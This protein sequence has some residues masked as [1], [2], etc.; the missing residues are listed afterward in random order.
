[1]TPVVRAK[2]DLL[3][4]AIREDIAMLAQ[5]CEIASKYIDL[6]RPDDGG[7]LYSLRS[8]VGHARIIAACARQLRDLRNPP[9]VITDTMVIDA[10]L[11]REEKPP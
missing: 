5:T 11:K 3:R 9:D 6:P 2:I 1:M 8:V 10:E 4:V 7:L